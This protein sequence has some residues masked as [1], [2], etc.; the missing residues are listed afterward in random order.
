MIAIFED[1]L[2]SYCLSIKNTFS[3]IDSKPAKLKIDKQNQMAP[4]YLF[5]SE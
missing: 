1:L 3:A 2:I 5:Y 4:N